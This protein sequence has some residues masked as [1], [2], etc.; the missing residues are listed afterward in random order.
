MSTYVFLWRNNGIIPKLFV[1]LDR[2]GETVQAGLNL[3]SLQVVAEKFLLS[4]FL[5]ELYNFIFVEFKF[6]VH[7]FHIT[8]CVDYLQRQ[9]TKNFDKLFRTF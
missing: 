2:T 1:L 5:V 6:L 8:V 9:E 4:V 3:C 7:F